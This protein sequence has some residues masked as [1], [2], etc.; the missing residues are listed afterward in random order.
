MSSREDRSDDGSGN[1]R[2]VF[3]VERDLS[4]STNPSGTGSTDKDMWYVV[5]LSYFS[6]PIF[7][8]LR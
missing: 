5:V 4:K 2:P 6:F 3:E 7:H 8:P 1:P